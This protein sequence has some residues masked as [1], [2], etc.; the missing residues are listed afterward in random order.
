VTSLR[1]DLRR[2][3]KRLEESVKALRAEIEA[4]S[5]S[6]EQTEARLQRLQVESSETRLRLEAKLKSQAE[7]HEHECIMIQKQADLM[8]GDVKSE[9]ESSISRL[10]KQIEAA[11]AESDTLVTGLREELKNKQVG[12]TNLIK[13]ELSFLKIFFVGK[14]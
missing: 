11:R 7:K 10:N 5:A 9:K 14:Y 4:K 3:R 8:I 1:A 12:L 13:F 6:L 2:N